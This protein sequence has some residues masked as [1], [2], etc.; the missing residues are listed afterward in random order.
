MPVVVGVMGHAASHPD[1]KD[2]VHF[3][4]GAQQS[5]GGVPGGRHSL[6][7]MTHRWQF[8]TH[9]PVRTYIAQSVDV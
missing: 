9:N 3:L 5:G 7:G 8:S 1:Q 4:E 2:V 6:T